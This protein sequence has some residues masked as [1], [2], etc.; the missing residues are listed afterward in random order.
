L[1]NQ[2]RFGL[3]EHPSTLSNH[4]SALTYGRSRTRVQ[5]LIA[6][7]QREFAVANSQRGR[8]DWRGDEFLGPAT[9][10]RRQQQHVGQLTAQMLLT[11]EK[12]GMNE[13]AVKV[14][15][16]RAYKVLRQKLESEKP[17]R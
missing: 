7:G 1:L 6:R 12:I 15:A 10:P 8:T 11:P 5:R 17:E 3:P 16:H 9:G 13:S 14:A 2:R 4:L